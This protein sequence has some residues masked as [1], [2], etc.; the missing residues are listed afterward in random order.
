MNI[1]LLGSGPNVTDAADW[2]RGPF[3]LIVAI[4]NAPLRPEAVAAL[5]A[6]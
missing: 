2:P 5:N 1:L 3:D 6:R 4:N